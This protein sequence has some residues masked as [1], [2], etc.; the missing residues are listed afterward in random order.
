MFQISVRPRRLLGSAIQFLSLSI[1]VGACPIAAHAEVQGGTSQTTLSGGTNQTALT[2]GASQNALTGGASQTALTGATNQTTL[3]GG[4]NSTSLSGSAG[5]TLLNGAAKIDALPSNA[6]QNLLRGNGKS[7]LLPA[8]ASQ[9]PLN[10]STK[11]G[12]LSGGAN[13][14][15]LN[16]NATT[17]TTGASRTPLQGGI[18][19]DASL[20]PSLRLLKPASSKAGQPLAPG[21]GT[22]F[23]PGQV[24]QIF[25][26][27]TSG[28]L[29]PVLQPSTTQPGVYQ[30]GLSGIIAPVS[31]YTMTRSNSRT[32]VAPG[33]EVTP[34]NTS[35][36]TAFVPPTS[37]SS[38]SMTQHGVTT[39]VPG[40]DVSS[41]SQSA[42]SAFSAVA[43]HG[44]GWGIA[45]YMPQYEVH[46]VTVT[47]PPMAYDPVAATTKG[48]TAFAPGYEVTVISH[49]KGAVTWTPGYEL[50]KL[51][52]GAYKETLS[53]V[54]HSGAPT[55]PLLASQGVLPQ[56]QFA[57]VLV[58]PTPMVATGLLLPQLR[59]QV[60]EKLTWD[61][62]YRRV[63]R[64][65]YC[66][67]QYAEV[68]PGCATIRMV[69]TKDRDIGCQLIDFTPAPDIKR[70]VAAETQF[71][72]AAVKAVN[73]VTKFEI[74]DLPP[75]D[76]DKVVFDLDLKRVVD[77]PV[78]VDVANRK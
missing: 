45:A 72:E 73:M 48:V 40:Y 53:G 50:S 29:A 61:E 9:T 70:D 1:C 14:N 24:T 22:T 76:S 54:W 37:S 64:A 6:N 67:W 27:T 11:T 58:G 60:L 7:G 30:R 4:T 71:R 77:G 57:K 69:V 78:G 13:Q 19:D 65:I 20:N 33:Y 59:A 51:V 32:W 55:P 66:R 46:K 26:H 68:G 34:A 21:I 49:N 56:P 41:I 8:N 17:L 15:L 23:I 47:S 3:T 42:G 75:L 10:G 35:R 2:G 38:A 62:W 12:T 5:Q 43:G 25:G 52:P 28:P 18:K 16:G 74:P 63:A 44:S 36:S 31:T 39:W